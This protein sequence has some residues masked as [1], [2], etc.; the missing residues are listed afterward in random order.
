M[1]KNVKTIFVDIG[2][3][4]ALLGISLGIWFYP[5]LTVVLLA[6]VLVCGC[7]PSQHSE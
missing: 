5:L 1:N 2:I 6:L 3:L 4:L 7:F